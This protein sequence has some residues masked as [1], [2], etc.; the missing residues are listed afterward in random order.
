MKKEENE[1]CN[2]MSG[3]ELDAQSLLFTDTND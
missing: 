2:N 1:M 3:S